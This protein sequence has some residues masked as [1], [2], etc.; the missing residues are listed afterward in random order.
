MFAG[1][2]MILGKYVHNSSWT[3]IILFLAGFIWLA[4]PKIIE[5]TKPQEIL[6]F[7]EVSIV[8]FCGILNAIALNM[9][10]DLFSLP[11]SGKWVAVVTG[12]IPV[13]A[14]AIGLFFGQKMSIMQIT[15]LCVVCLGMWM[16]NK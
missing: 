13:F 14:L 4:V 1:F 8:V 12:L 5:S 16:M 3:N 2:P 10:K 11:D 6:T 15:G 7:R 9:Y